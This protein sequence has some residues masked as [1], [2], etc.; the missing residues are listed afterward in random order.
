MGK[1]TTNCRYC[2]R[3]SEWDFSEEHNMNA[4]NC[5]HW[6]KKYK[7]QRNS[8]WVYPDMVFSCEHFVRADADTESVRELEE[9]MFKLQKENEA[10][11]K[12]LKQFID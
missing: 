11:H 10:L 8:I 2:D 5:G 6:E 1:N 7:M 4:F 12:E 3:M 9:K